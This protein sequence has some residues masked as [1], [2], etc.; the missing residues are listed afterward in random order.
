MTESLLAAARTRELEAG[1]IGQA[2]LDDVVDAARE[3]AERRIVR[4]GEAR[5]IRAA[6]DRLLRGGGVIAVEAD[7]QREIEDAEDRREL[8]QHLVIRARVELPES[9]QRIGLPGERAEAQQRLFLRQL[10]QRRLRERDCV[11]RDRRAR[12]ASS[13]S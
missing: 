4:L 5:R 1:G 12:Y 8:L 11:D 9:P 13:P 7:R 6:I 10:R 2:E 3:H